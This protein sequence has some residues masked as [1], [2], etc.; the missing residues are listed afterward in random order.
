MKKAEKNHFFLF[1][2]KYEVKRY[3]DVESSYE[4]TVPIKP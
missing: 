2:Q 3:V 1:L 4:V